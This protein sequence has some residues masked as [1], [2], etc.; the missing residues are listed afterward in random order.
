MA[1]LQLPV[2]VTIFSCWHN[3]MREL[4]KSIY[5][6]LDQEGVD[7]EYIVIDDASTD[8][9]AEL[10]AAIEHPRFRLIRN[11][12]NIGFVRSARK[13]VA[14]GTGDYVAVHGAGDISLPGRLAAQAALLDANPEVVV[15]GVG[16]ENV[17]VTTGVR[18]RHGTRH[19]NP[20]PP[21][22]KMKYTG[23][24][25]MFRRAAYELVGGY[26]EIFYYSQDTDLWLRM[27][28][29]GRVDTVDDVY[30]ERRIFADGVEG[31]P[32]KKVRQAQFASLAGHAATERAAG[33]SD[34]VE[35][36]HALALLAQPHSAEMRQ[37]IG[38]MVVRPLLKKRQFTQARAALETAP[39]GALSWKML[40][41]LLA[42]RVFLRQR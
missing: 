27:N 2:R 6:V 16:V 20:T 15:T 32:M 38:R 25:V 23:G 12:T 10:L 3:R 41:A 33:R 42:L 29:I 4:E 9:T 36:F 24:E 31:N 14:L 21:N 28:E 37:R 26:R 35:H 22:L 1:D 40:M 34:P 7:L 30:Y 11:D 17:D 13:A 18:R 5:S 19:K 39:A 8:G